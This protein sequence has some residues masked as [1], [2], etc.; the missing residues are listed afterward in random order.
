MA[1]RIISL[2]LS[3][4]ICFSMPV[5]L[6]AEDKLDIQA[7]SAILMDYNTGE[8]LY[9]KNPH[10]KVPPASISKIMTLLL[11][12]EALESGKIKL[13]DNVRISAH[14]AGMGGSQLWLEEG[15]SQ[16]VENLLKAITIRS[17]N[18]ASVALAEY[19]AGS[20]ELFVRMMNDKAKAL[21]MKNTNFMNASGLPNEEQYVSAYDV[22]LMSKELLK[23]DEIHKWLTVYMDEL[24]VGKKKDKVQSLVNTNRLIKDYEG[25]TGIKTGSTSKAGYC[26][27]ASAKR[28]NLQLI[29]VVMGCETSKIRF[30]EAMR[31][32]DYGF[33]NYD[34]ITI[35]RKGDILGKV[36]VH[37]GSISSIEVILERDSFILISK[38]DKAN[39]SKEIVLPE[40]IEGPVEKGQ[41]IG[42]LIIRVDGSLVDR[43]NLV[44]KTRVEKAGFKEMFKKTVK[45]LLI[46]K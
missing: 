36:Q 21:G 2:I 27:A 29:A 44:S 46:A 22:A 33:A 4:I 12:M 5:E 7:K 6:F 43:I 20:E 38:G 37:K 17:A 13:S 39:I 28:G 31:L 23:H 18:D 9:E 35:G 42:H 15:E 11:A 30:D 45:S 14:A 41:E 26:L 24:L 25:A 19:I 8:I 1:R 10:D 40:Y 34:S 3:L 32:L 16:T